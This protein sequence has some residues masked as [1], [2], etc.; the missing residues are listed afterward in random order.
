MA[1]LLSGTRFFVFE[2]LST[3]LQA[4]NTTLSEAKMPPSWSKAV[5]SV[6]PKEGKDQLDVPYTTSVLNVDYELYTVQPSLPE[7]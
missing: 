6:I 5:I 4:C 3:L 7:D 2:L 1:F